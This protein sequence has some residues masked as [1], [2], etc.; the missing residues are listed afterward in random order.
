VLHVQNLSK[1]FG[2]TPVLDDV[3]FVVND[4]EHVALIGPNGSG[5]STIV[6]CLVADEQPDSGSIV[7]A[8][9]GARIGY[10]P[11]SFAEHNNRTLAD[12]QAEFFEAEHAVQR[13]ADALGDAADPSA[14]L[15]EY[16]RCLARFEAHDG[17]ERAARVAAV[18]D[19]L[20]LSYVEPSTP[21]GE[22]SGGQK[23]RLGLATLLL[24]EPD[25]LVLDEPTNHLDVDALEW[26]EQWS[27]AII[28]RRRS[29]RLTAR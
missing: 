20:E 13:A 1:S 25:L 2:V 19:G 11:Q 14:A 7:L 10:L 29:S 3:S 26:L 23:T 6:R 4:G 8:P 28:S 22:L 5:K 12:I 21:L 16:E 9:P 18:L 24:R 27:R 17:Y 15:A